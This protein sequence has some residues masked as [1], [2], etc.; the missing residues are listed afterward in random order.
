MGKS[1]LLNQVLRQHVSITSD[2][3]QTTRNA[4]RGVL[5]EDGWQVVFVDT[6][7]LHRPQTKL[8]EK[9]NSVVRTTLRDV[10]IIVLLLDASVPIG[11][12]D[13]FL[14]DEVSA[15]ETPALCVLNKSDLTDAEHLAAQREV[16]WRLG[17]F[18]ELYA[19]S[20]RTGE[21]V[22]DLID[23]IRRR[24]PEGPQWYPPGMV[25]DQPEKVIVAELVREQVLRQV[26]EEVP[27]SVAVAVSEMRERDDGMMEIDAEIYVERDSQKGIIIGKRGA[28]LKE[29]G[30]KA[31]PHIEALLGAKVMLRLRV[32][33]EPHWQRREQMI[34]RFGYG[35]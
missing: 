18:H 6:P 3:P 31:R 17:S 25:T 23:A 13:T 15:V 34:T 24:L 2:R 11:K 19:V 35:S 10:D 8:G 22:A 33:V 32:K 4:V 30:S 28:A 26:S 16:A 20:A 27:H 7:G 9:L 14:A 21:G 1:T 5:T 29:T 12:G